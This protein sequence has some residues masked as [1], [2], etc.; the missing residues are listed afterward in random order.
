MSTTTAFIGI[1]KYRDP[2]I[3]NL[4]GE[5]RDAVA[6]EALFADTI[7]DLDARLPDRPWFTSTSRSAR[8]CATGAARML[9]APMRAAFTPSVAGYAIPCGCHEDGIPGSAE[10]DRLS[11]C[12]HYLSV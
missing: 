2:A 5:K 9:A 1:N 7:P 8:A 12:C 4:S 10:T 6:L 3:S 11:R